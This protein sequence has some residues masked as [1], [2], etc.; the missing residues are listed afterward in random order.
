MTEVDAR[1]PIDLVEAG[2]TLHRAGQLEEAERLY[3]QALARDEDCAEAHELKAVIAGQRGQSD[4]AIAG[5]RRTIALGGPTPQRLYNLAEAYRLACDFES[6]LGAYNQALTLDAG[7]LDAYRNCAEAA[8]EMAAL[9]AAQGN[10]DAAER[11]NRVAAHYLTGLG[12]ACLKGRDVVAAEKA[13]RAS[14]VLDPQKAESYSNLGTIAIESYRLIEAETQYRSAQSLEPQS[15]AYV[16]NLGLALLAQLRIDDA[17]ES[18]RKAIE[19]DPSFEDARV[20]LDRLLLWRHYRADWG[21]DAMFE[22]HRDWGRGA[23]AR[24]ASDA[25]AMPPFTNRRDPDRILR[26]AFIALDFSSYD[27]HLFFEPLAGQLDRSAFEL[28]V[29]RTPS[30]IGGAEIQRLKELTKGR[31]M[32][33]PHRT[34]EFARMIRADRIDIAIDPVGHM[35]HG[36]LDIF[37]LKPA[38]VCVAWLGYP[39]TTGL[40]TIDYRITDEVADPPGAEALY[41]EQLYRLEGGSF[42]FRPPEQAPEIT[43]LPARDAE[44]VTFGNF[45]DPRKI[46]PEVLQVWNSTLA[47][48]PR[49]RILLIAPEFAEDAYVARFHAQVR[50][51]GID[52]EKVQ[53][54]HPPEE[55]DW[56]LRAYSEVDVVLDTFPYNSSRARTCEALWSGAPVITLWGDR[57]CSR[58][59]ASVLAQIGLEGLISETGDRYAATAVELACDLERLRALRAGMRERMRFSPLMDEAG[60]ARRFEAALRDMWRD[61]CRSAS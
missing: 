2:R 6:A 55:R 60:F 1:S 45:E 44:V 40:P 36:R 38:P 24:V 26:V 59:S 50:A 49:A 37:A 56:R 13:Y 31:R 48:L 7:F 16:S 61:W 39:D 10:I 42:V 9:A 12:H 29:Y 57:P 52:P 23:V 58:M 20:N 27:S 28:V 25:R 43:A 18:F 51:A 11:F 8:K 19:L 30:E 15:P 41:T 21:P 47:S 5:F 53:I 33:F 32:L 22:M 54:R 17:A 46:A 3:A 4:E 14:I 35:L 34:K